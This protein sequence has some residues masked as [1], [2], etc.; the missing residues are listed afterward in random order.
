MTAF[1]HYLSYD[2]KNG[3]RE[4]SLLLLNYLFPLGLFIMMGFLL[5][6]V[7]PD[8][9]T[10]IIPAMI[11][12]STMSVTLLGMPNPIV[13]DRLAG[14]YRSFKIN[15]IPA[16]HIL[17]VP[18]LGNL[19][20]VIIVSVLITIIGYPLFDASL[21]VNWLAFGLIVL[22]QF[23]AMAGLGMLIGVISPNGNTTVLFSQ[24][25]FLPSMI[26]GGLMMSFDFLSPAMQ[27]LALLLPATHAMNAFRGFAYGWETSFNPAWSVGV[28]LF[29]GL[30]AFAMAVV[31][32]QWDSRNIKRGRSPFLA[33]LA[34]VPYLA[35]VLLY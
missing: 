7:N 2:F 30:T 8:F 3:L 11:I 33:I 4:K 15:G 14:V 19:V 13:A 21:P 12:I 16:A 18:P 22:V 26:I 20:H 31:L 5:T 29:G 6:G 9:K 27:R 24:L 25:I 32:F 28:L 34:L 10:T 1:F 35:A 17:A 23:F